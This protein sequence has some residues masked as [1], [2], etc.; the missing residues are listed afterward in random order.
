MT[1]EQFDEHVARE[2]QRLDRERAGYEWLHA[3]TRDER[4]AALGRG[5]ATRTNNT[6]TVLAGADHA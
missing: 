4:S 1:L 5:I 6:F 2:Q 3:T